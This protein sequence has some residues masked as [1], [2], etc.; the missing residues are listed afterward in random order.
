MLGLRLPANTRVPMG[1]TKVLQLA[2]GFHYNVGMCGTGAPNWTNND[3]G[4]TSALVS[5]QA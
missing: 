2:A 3:W 4:Q 5:D 1:V